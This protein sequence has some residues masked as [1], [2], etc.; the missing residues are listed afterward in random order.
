MG[1]TFVDVLYFYFNLSYSCRIVETVF[2]NVR[3]ICEKVISEGS[4]RKDVVNWLK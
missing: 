4:R 1:L 2:K 3:R